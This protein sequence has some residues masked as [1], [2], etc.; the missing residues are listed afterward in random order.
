MPAKRK[1]SALSMQPSSSGSAEKRLKQEPALGPPSVFWS[2]V[3]KS[4]RVSA[5]SM[6]LSA[7]S[8]QNSI[9]GRRIASMMPPGNDVKE[10]KPVVAAPKPVLSGSLQRVSAKPTSTSTKQSSGNKTATRSA[11]KA[12]TNARRVLSF[13]NGQT[14]V[15]T[16]AA[17]EIRKKDKFVETERPYFPGD[18]MAWVDSAFSAIAVIFLV[19]A[20]S[21]CFFAAVTF[22]ST[23]IPF[24]ISV[25]ESKPVVPKTY[26]ESAYDYA[27]ETTVSLSTYTR[28]LFETTPVQTAS[29][30]TTKKTTK[31]SMT[32]SQSTKMPIQSAANGKN[33]LGTIRSSEQNT[34]YDY[35]VS[36]LQY[37]GVVFEPQKKAHPA[38]AW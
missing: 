5:E 18:N 34:L 4:M 6:R 15:Q 11:F 7:E 10:R 25:P 17:E 20:A 33:P 26:L 27:F 31:T 28:S 22:L 2:N 1:S 36:G 19:A 38:T 23:T 24:F 37:L 3:S 21:Y 35:M 32:S 29:S 9:I 16:E 30:K 8:I 12:G 13:A 14:G